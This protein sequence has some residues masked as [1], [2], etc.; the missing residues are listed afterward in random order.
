MKNEN[1]V[2]KLGYD[3]LDPSSIVQKARNYCEEGKW[4][5]ELA[6]WEILQTRY[7]SYSELTK[8]GNFILKNPF[9]NN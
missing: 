9:S 3:G 2:R 1:W 8:R 4:Q 5:E 7:S 6:G